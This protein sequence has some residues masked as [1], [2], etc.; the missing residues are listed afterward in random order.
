MSIRD[1]DEWLEADRA[2]GFASGTVSTIRTRRYQALVLVA[3]TPPT[4]RV[5]LVNGFEGW[6]ETP[7]G[8]AA[9]TSQRYVPGVVDP[10]GAARITAFQREPWPRWEFTLANGTALTQEIFVAPGSGQT[11]LR[12]R[13][14]AGPVP[15]RLCVRLLMSGRDAGSLHR[16]N[17]AFP[18]E[19]KA[20]G[21]TVRFGAYPGLPAVTAYGA[22][23]WEAAPEWYRQFLYTVEQDRGLDCVE[24]LGSPGIL[25]WDLAVGEA[26]L[27]LR[28][29]DAPPMPVPALAR[30]EQARRAQPSLRLSADSYLSA[31]GTGRTVLAGF[32]WFTD[33]GRDTFISIRGLLIA[34]GRVAEATEILLEWAGMVDQG[35]V[36]N[37]FPDDAGPAEFNA[38]D[39]SLWFVIAVH[40]LLRAGGVPADAIMRL[41]TAGEA[42]LAGYSAGA[43]YRIGADADGLIRAGVPGVQLTWMD[44]KVGDWVVTPRIG[45]PV[46]VQALWINALRI[47]DGWSGRWGALA[48]KATAALLAR[49]PDPETGGLYDV[50]DV[51]HQVGAINRQ[52]RPNQIFAVGGL[53][54]PLLPEALARSVVML[55]ERELLTPLGLRTLAPSDPA[56]RPRYQGNLVERDGAYHQGTVWPWLIGPFVEAWLRVRGNTDMARAEARSRFL[57]PLL[58][59]LETGGLGH[60][61]ECADGDAP[62]T[63]GGCPFQAWSL[64]E[65][66]RLEALL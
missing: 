34:Q 51:D 12:W 21:G 10:D 65:L 32:P 61:T 26:T 52:V 33:W 17:A 14:R 54:F 20:E 41:K 27:V 43:R 24:D 31:R 3:Q 39:A 18:F 58:A 57:P 4:S 53:P 55:V 50:V 62:H 9:L 29:D 48:Q 16:E 15:C 11:V 2:G 56:Y 59:H 30:A 63:P 60:I 7:G 22:D 1:V 45:K 23:A 64:G 38:V 13:R 25:S 36:P 37:R 66:L 44:A 5:V 19:A 35:M 8:R 28:A 47:A 40:D 6:V 42:I 49:F 46:E